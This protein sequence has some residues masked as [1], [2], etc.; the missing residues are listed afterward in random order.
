MMPDLPTL[1][2]AY[3]QQANGSASS[4]GQQRPLTDAER[5]DLAAFKTQLLSQL[6]YLNTLEQADVA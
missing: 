3:Q 6:A 4:S 5:R 2:P 1:H